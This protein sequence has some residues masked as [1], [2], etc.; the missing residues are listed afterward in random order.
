M[1]NTSMHTGMPS[2]P[3][4]WG[5]Q[6]PSWPRSHQKHCSRELQGRQVV[7]LG[8][9]WT[10]VGQ[11]GAGMYEACTAA[12]AQHPAHSYLLRN[13]GCALRPLLRTGLASRW[14]KPWQSLRS[15]CQTPS[16]RGRPT[17][18]RYTCLPAGALAETKLVCKQGAGGWTAPQHLVQHQQC[19]AGRHFCHCPQHSFRD[20]LG[21][22]LPAQL[23]GWT[24]ASLG[25]KIPLVLLAAVPLVLS[26]GLVYS[27]ATG[28]WEAM[29]CAKVPHHGT[30]REAA[31]MEENPAG[32]EDGCKGSRQQRLSWSGLCIL[33]SRC[34]CYPLQAHH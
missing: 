32:K 20:D 13:M 29:R 3:P 28:Q 24:Y 2:E 30:E 33:L 9:A 31:C 14:P 27:R 6:Q 7:C 5:Q 4:C 25:M 22:R 12:H 15:R 10:M 17:Y 1:A 16:W 19:H 11:P 8:G 23:Q 21:D 18:S 26:L 34:R